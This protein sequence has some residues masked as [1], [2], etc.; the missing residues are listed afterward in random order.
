[1]TF[2]YKKI[3][4]QTAC[5]VLASYAVSASA[6]FL[7]ASETKD[8]K[9]NKALAVPFTNVKI[10][11]K[12]WSPRIKTN[13]N[14]SLPHNFKWCEE[15]G[16]FSNFAK[17]GGLEKGKF[18]GKYFNDSDVYK[19]L[20]GASYCLADRPDA[21]LDAMVDDVIAK[22]AAAQED[23][24]YLNSYFTLVTPDKKWTNCASQHELY[25]AGH[26]FEAAVAHHRAT[27]KRNLLDVAL[28]FANYIDNMFG[29]GK[30]VDVPGHEEIELALV[31]LYE[32][33]GEKRYLDL[34][35]F[36]LDVRGD[37]SKRKIYGEYLQD[38]IP[39]R[40]QSEIVGHAVRAMYLFCGVADVAAHTGDK[41]FIESCDRIWHNTVERKTY[42]TGG[43]GATRVGEAFGDDY[44]LPNKSAYC[45]TCAAIGML[46][47]NHRLNLMHQDAKYMDTFERTLYN[48]FLSGIGLDGKMF[49]YVNPL[50]SD[51][52]HHRKPF[53]PCACCPTNVVR[54]LP[55]LPGYVYA[56]SGDNIFV[57]LYIGGSGKIDLSGN[58]IQ[59]EQKTLYP[60]DG[61]VKFT[62]TPAKPQKFAINLRIP[63]WSDTCSIAVN[64]KPVDN[65][66]LEKGYA[67][68][69]RL[70]KPGDT[71]ELNLPMT[72]K[73]IEANPKVA[74]DRG[75]VAIQRGPIV[76]CFEGVD[77]CI[78]RQSF[79]KSIMLPRDPK[80][81][82]KHHSDLLGGVTVITGHDVAG[83]KITAV[84]YYAWD[85]RAPGDMAVWVYQDGKSRKPPLDDPAWN[86][87]LYRPLDPKTLGPSEPLPATTMAVVSASH[88]HDTLS[89]LND[90]NLPSDSCDH[91]IPRFTWWDHRGTREWV[92][93]DFFKPIKVKSTE[94]Y[95]FDDERINQN[96]RAPKSWRLLYRSGEQWKPVAA[97]SSYGTK[98][99][100]MNRVTFKPVETTALRLEVELVPNFSS[101]IL[102]WK[103]E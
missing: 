47:W 77:N 100:C 84:P 33:T 94:V 92:Q 93:Y 76:Y 102:E 13:R 40:E 64:G 6:L 37:A 85:N 8:A 45:E 9:A 75:R 63:A 50:A 32:L 59:I 21:K 88:T 66:T 49:F 30:R 70:W 19:V 82:A 68:L 61:H 65:A 86:N 10:N 39:V 73:R 7:S 72:I 78:D 89:A 34:A 44:Q 87:K 55:S 96:C 31:K 67:R 53:Y 54:V 28:K 57:N 25:C 23:D 74:A 60:W 38:H 22:I 80:F 42:I 58:A 103:V 11:D 4:C 14:E 95:W 17:A 16:R 90:D 56:R 12:F 3:I 29:S 15:T 1:M 98:L 81:T 48:G 99:D 97:T 18:E 101:G 83:R 71:V 20:E 24:G 35:Q 43:I 5:L 2:M 26:L 62:I 79:V 91:K 52:T 27:G 41:G 36:F 46:L 51:G 69:E